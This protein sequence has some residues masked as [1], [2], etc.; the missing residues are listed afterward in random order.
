MQ[1]PNGVRREAIQAPAEPLLTERA[2]VPCGVG[3]RLVGDREDQ[4]RELRMLGPDAFLTRSFAA[5][6]LPTR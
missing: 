5:F 3:L 4:A 1:Q 2:G 6:E